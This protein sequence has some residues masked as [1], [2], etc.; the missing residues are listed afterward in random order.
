MGKILSVT[1]LWLSLLLGSSP[2][3]S[4]AEERNLTLQ[5]LALAP[6]AGGQTVWALR[7]SSALA[8]GGTEYTLFGNEYLITGN[9]PLMG[10]VYSWRFPIIGRKWPIQSFAQLGLGASSAGPMTELLWSISPFWVIRIDFAT[11]F[12]ARLDR[13]IVWNYPSWIGL[14]VPF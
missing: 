7:Y 3:R 8:S 1:L 6:N 13:A 12:Y 14:T 9:Y 11:H 10:G 2:G 5:A 4:A